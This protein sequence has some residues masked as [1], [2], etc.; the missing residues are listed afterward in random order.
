MKSEELVFGVSDFVSIFNQTLE[1]AYPSV[2][3]VGELANFKISKNRWVYFDLK[4]EQASI[5]FF[6]S[7]YMLPGPLEDGLLL[8]V[9]GTPKLHPQFGFS[10]NVNTIQPVGEGSIKRASQLLEAKLR[11]EG[12]FEP[13]RKR[14]LPYP[15][16]SVGLIASSESAAF[17][18][19]IKV[20]NGRWGG[21]EIRLADVQVQGEVSPRQ[22]VA[23]VDYFNQQAQPPEVLVVTRGGGSAEDLAA[24]STELVTRSIAASR[25]PTVVAVGHEVDISLAE[26][27]ADLRASTPSNAAELIVPDKR[28]EMERLIT[29]KQALDQRIRSIVVDLQT[30]LKQQLNQFS[31]LLTHQFIQ[32]KQNLISKHNLLVA[33]NPANILG[34]GYAILRL[35]GKVIR[36]GK[37]ISVG[38]TFSAQIADASI[39]ARADEVILQ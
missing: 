34:R 21:I 26:L 9:R 23:A 15:P 5:R 24:F 7:V 33:L 13:A 39:K 12:L 17:H 16:Q 32:A 25:I 8:Q 30:D 38:K 4:D 31:T 2:V 20:I 27:A 35:D 28:Q 22:I 18:D 3:I 29:S 11:A 37:Q 36:S 1:Y 10:I 6:G 14:L 19:F